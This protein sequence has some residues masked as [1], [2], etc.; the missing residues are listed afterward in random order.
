MNNTFPSDLRDEIWRAN[1]GLPGAGL[2]VGTSGNVSGRDP[3]T[4]LIAIKPSGVPFSD[5]QPE[6]LVVV[7]ES[8]RVVEGTLKPSVDT[9][10]HCLVYRGR[11]DVHGVVHTHSRYATA[12]AIRGESIP[13]LSTTH[14]ALFGGPIPVSDYAVIGEEEIGREIVRHVGD[15]SAVLMRSHGVFTIGTSVSKAMRAATYTE[16]CAE[17]AHLAL[18]RGHVDPMATETV[19]ESRRWYLSDYGQLATEEGA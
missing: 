2:V 14:A 7:E 19:A 6:H 9:M 12:F 5:L 1:C 18:Q 16:E 10:S 3:V 4:G 17:H 11:N 13:V 8:G 15:G